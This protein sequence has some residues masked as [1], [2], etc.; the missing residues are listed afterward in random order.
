MFKRRYW[1]QAQKAEATCDKDGR[2]TLQMSLERWQWL[3]KDI[4]VAKRFGQWRYEQD[5]QIEENHAYRC[6]KWLT[7]VDNCVDLGCGRHAP[8]KICRSRHAEHVVGRPTETSHFKLSP[9]WPKL[10]VDD[11]KAWWGWLLSVRYPIAGDDSIW[12]GWRAPDDAGRRV[13]DLGEG[14]AG[15]WSGNW[16]IDS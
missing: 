5:M 7:S 6:S 8:A 4:G 11:R 15:R 9:C 12:F 2:R 10:V 16:E 1:R 13:G 14:D 3:E